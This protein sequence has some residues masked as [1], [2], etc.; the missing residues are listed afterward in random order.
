MK[1]KITPIPYGKQSLSK[2]DKLA[3]LK[4]LDNPWLTQGPQVEIFEKQ[5]AQYCGA[6]HAVVFCNGTAALHATTY[7]ADVQNG[8][9]GITSA[10]TFV[11][12]ANCVRFQGGEVRLAD[13]NPATAQITADTVKPHLTRRT[14]VLIPVDYAGRSSEL[15]DLAKL[16]RQHKLTLILDAC[17][18][19]GGSYTTG[20][21]TKK[22]GA[23]DLADM[24]VFSFHP[25]KSITT[26]EGGVVLTNN[27]LFYQRLKLFR[28]HGI[29][30]NPADAINKKLST[31]AWYYEMQD[32]GYNYRLTDFQCALGV[33]QL[34]NLDLKINKRKR[35]VD[36]YKKQLRGIVGMLDSDDNGRSAHHIFPI[37]VDPKKRDAIFKSLHKKGI[38][39]QLH[40]IPVYHQPYYKNRY[41][42]DVHDFPHTEV[43]FKSALS[44]PVF[45]DLTIKQMQYVVKTLKAC[46]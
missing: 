33:S 18:S 16:A 19:L 15:V 21:R 5:L 11:A 8:D 3:V 9:E 7:A 38:L 24:T 22:I 28:I 43:F 14:K 46:L 20:G 44:L 27:D 25:V 31:N 12:S 29:T 4:A 40:Y 36:Y 17:H 39:C 6:K 2:A 10:L 37:L 32:L 23:C 35:I 42:F 45:P 26:G 13:I 34:K 30:K 1:S 41:G